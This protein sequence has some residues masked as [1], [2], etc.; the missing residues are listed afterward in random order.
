MPASP[1]EAL[2]GRL[3]G[4]PAGVLVER[5]RLEVRFAGAKEAVRRLYALAQALVSNFERFEALVGEERSPKAPAQGEC[6]GVRLET[7]S[8]RRERECPGAGSAGSRQGMRASPIRW[9]VHGR[10]ALVGIPAAWDPGVRCGGSDGG[11]FSVMVRCRSRMTIRGARRKGEV[12]ITVDGAPLDWRSSLA[13]RN[14]SPT[15]PAWGYGGSG[16]AQ[17]ALA[18]LL[19]VT[20]E[21]TAELFYQTFKWS[22]IAPIEADRWTLD[23]GDV[24]GWLESAAADDI[25]SLAV[26]ER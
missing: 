9:R 6:A 26:E 3:S 19:A 18:I 11:R 12:L 17:L 8:G 23:A 15:G 22:V 20:D 24:L 4:L 10:C 14:H 5:D 1:A 21:A 13:V 16:P 7:R 25:V 2:Q